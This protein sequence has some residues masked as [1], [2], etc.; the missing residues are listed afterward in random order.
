M[1]RKRNLAAD[2]LGL[3]LAIVVRRPTSPI[4]PVPAWSPSSCWGASPG[5]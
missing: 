1:G 2:T 4:G 3:L 5:W